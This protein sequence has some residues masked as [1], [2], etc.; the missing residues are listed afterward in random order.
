M[1]SAGGA[2]AGPLRS[3]CSSPGVRGLIEVPIVAE[4]LAS[5]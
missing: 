5:R 1:L 2:T 3:F 4:S